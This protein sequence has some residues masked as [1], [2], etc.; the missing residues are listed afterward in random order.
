MGANNNNNDNAA[1]WNAAGQTASAAVGAFAQGKLNKKTR[2]WN[3]SMYQRQ[4]NDNIKLWNMQNEYNSPMA[5]MQRLKDANLNPNLVYGTGTVANNASTPKSGELKSWNPRT[6]DIAAI[7]NGFAAYQNFALQKAQI[8]NLEAGTRVKVG[9][10]LLRALSLKTGDFDFSQKQALKDV[11]IE[12]AKANLRSIDVRSKFSEDENV[13]QWAMQPYNLQ[14]AA[15]D[16]AGKEIDNKVKNFDFK[17]IKPQQL[18]LIKQR[19]KNLVMDWDLDNFEKELN[20]KGFTR[21]D[22]YFIRAGIKALDG[23]KDAAGEI[24][25]KIFNVPGAWKHMK[26]YAP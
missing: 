26:K 20:A 12:T 9:D 8:D 1:M 15:L 11:Y 13:R 2:E 17:Y 25:E 19:I 18:E 7:G 21:S 24:V 22:P 3:E 4:L 6:P 10:A 14:R 16:V 5:Q 23:V